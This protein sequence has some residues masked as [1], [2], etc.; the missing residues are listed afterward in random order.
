[1][2]KIQ[3][4]FLGIPKFEISSKPIE[5]TTAKAIALLAY[6]AVNR[7][8]QNR[9]RILGLLWADSAN[10]AARKNLRNLLWTIRKTLSDDVIDADDDKLSL[11]KSVWTDVREFENIDSKSSIENLKSQ[12][13]LYRTPLLDGLAFSDSS[14]FEIWLAAE[15]E[16]LTQLVLRTYD[17]LAKAQTANADWHSVIETAQR[18]LALDN[19]QEPIHRALMQ[20]YAQLGERTKALRQYD[21]LRATLERELGVTPLPE[22]DELRTTIANGNLAPI[23][24]TSTSQSLTI[25]PTEARPRNATPFIGRT[26][27][28]TA[29]DDELANAQT[30]HTRIALVVGELGIGKT[31]LWNEWSSN[32]NGVTRLETRGLQSTQSHPFAPIIDLLGHHPIREKI[33]SRTSTVPTIWLAQLARLIPQVRNSFSDLPT[34]SQLPPEEERQRLFESLTQCLLA[35]SEPIILFLDDAHWIDRATLDWVDYLAHR[36]HNHRLLIV[37]AYRAEDAPASLIHRIASWGREGIAKR[38]PLTRLS[39]DESTALAALLSGD[40]TRAERAEMQSAGNPYFLIEL[41][42]ASSNDIPSALN[43]LIRVRID[44]LDETARQIAQ[45]AAI[46]EPDFDFATI[47]RTSGRGEEET[48]NG[49][50]TL[51]ANNI[52]IERQAGFEFSHPLVATVLRDSMSHARCV[53]LH[54]R[55]AEALEATHTNQINQIAGR[56]AEHYAQANDAPRAAHFAELAAEN[57]LALASPAE[58]IVFYHQAIALEWTPTRQMGLGVASMRYGDLPG[59]RAAFESALQGFQNAHDAKNA[60]RAC[61]NIA[62][63]FYPAGRF[64]EGREWM[65]KG[66]ELLGTVTDPASH[67]LAHLLLA[68]SRRD[69]GQLTDE[70]VKHARESIHIADEN[71]L[72]NLSARARFI[73]GNLLA[74]RGALEEAIR[75]FVE[76]VQ[77]AHQARDHYQQI[78]SYNNA[79]YHALLVSDIAAARQYID[80]GF[81]LTH[82]HAMKLPLQYLYSTR[83]QIALAEKSWD[84]AI[85]WFTRALEASQEH[86]NREQVADDKMNLAIAARGKGDLDNALALL[87]QARDQA[88]SLNAQHMQTQIELRLAEL[89]WERGEHTAA[90][91]SLTRAEER[92]KDGSREKL[93]GWAKQLRETLGKKKR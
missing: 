70:T 48:L 25:R 77:L 74:E 56:L 91:E 89:Y 66:L 12:I 7:E 75:V 86:D 31:R 20:A 78:L 54:R 92:L 26:N 21:L 57:A 58:A 84:V 83:G 76:S 49:L 34:T 51:V 36:L 4:Y 2:E 38:I 11:G 85:D 13:A 44:S 81:A 55:A 45:T 1:V 5:L 68:S 28:R 17:S 88:Q 72:A 16:R 52:L 62:E 50:D 35:L 47:R 46:L 24:I 19:L 27:E 64:D 9:E 65:E 69:A 30:G 6:L 37:V 43:D 71:N 82:T 41:L 33:C 40:A 39:P 90:N 87:E 61:M 67:A 42:R 23:T 59:A 22:T 8:P 18:A 15:R 73:L 32:Q 79:A 63:T 80:E 14:E 3:L 29:L 93:I 60:V 10:D 53:F